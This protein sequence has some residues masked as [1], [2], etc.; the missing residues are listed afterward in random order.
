MLT[1]YSAALLIEG[2]IVS[3]IH[4][5]NIDNVEYLSLSLANIMAIGKLAKQLTK[6]LNFWD[7]RLC[8]VLLM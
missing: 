5:F 6:Q 4:P 2:R 1:T 8:I 7:L 3:L